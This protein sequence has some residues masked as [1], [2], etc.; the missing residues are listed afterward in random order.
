MYIIYI[1]EYAHIFACLP[2]P[3][4]R[5]R[6]KW[7]VGGQIFLGVFRSVFLKP[8]GKGRRVGLMCIFGKG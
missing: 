5:C 2:H 8:G 1:T 6:G 7:Q 3:A 4:I